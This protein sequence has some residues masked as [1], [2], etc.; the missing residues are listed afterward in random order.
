MRRVTSRIPFHPFHLVCWNLFAFSVWQ[1]PSSDLALEP[2]FGSYS[3]YVTAT[4]WVYSTSVYIAANLAPIVS[5]DGTKRRK[6]KQNKYIF[7][8]VN[9]CSQGYTLVSEYSSFGRKNK[10]CSLPT[11]KSESCCQRDLS[12]KKAYIKGDMA[13]TFRVDWN[14]ISGGAFWLVLISLV[15]YVVGMSTV[16]WATNTTYK[17]QVGLWDAC[18]CG[19]LPSS[20]CK[21]FLLAFMVNIFTHM[22]HE[23]KS[24]K[25]FNTGRHLYS[26]ISFLSR[27]YVHVF[28]FHFFLEL[29]RRRNKNFAAWRK[30]R[31]SKQQMK[32]SSQVSYSVASVTFA[33]WLKATQAMIILG[34]LC[35]FAGFVL[36]FL[37]LFVERFKNSK[38]MI[39]IISVLGVSGIDMN[40]NLQPSV[41]IASKN[42]NLFLF[43]SIKTNQDWI[44]EQKVLTFFEETW[45]CLFGMH[46]RGLCNPKRDG[47]SCQLEKQLLIH[48]LFAVL[49]FP[50][51]DV[52]LYDSSVV[53][54]H[55]FHRVWSWISIT[56]IPVQ[57]VALVLLCFHRDWNYWSDSSVYLIC[58]SLEKEQNFFMICK[59]SGEEWGLAD[60]KWNAW[61][62]SVKTNPCMY[63]VELLSSAFFGWCI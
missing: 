54:P 32:L 9:I 20:P 47:V 30:V 28:L 58:G 1:S 24:K 25:Y 62:S 63:A 26:F 19:M 60:W 38:M 39:A 46:K 57:C 8:L 3:T 56:V 53:L 4:E 44:N 40:T 11:D 27:S 15:F 41:F 49:T 31:I 35:L 37:Y 5:F 21:S 2:L 33:A 12:P 61:N 34:G 29:F 36:G 18:Q 23:I 10:I 42:G 45:H 48:V 6:S 13:D 51:L 59:I 7:F 52:L 14:G 43:F 16:G 22:K 55:R 50:K 17:F